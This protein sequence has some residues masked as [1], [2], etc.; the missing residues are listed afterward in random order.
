MD[1]KVILEIELSGWLVNFPLPLRHLLCNT[2]VCWVGLLE[3]CGI[4]RICWVWRLVIPAS[5]PAV[6]FAATWTLVIYICLILAI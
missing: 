2:A 6:H 4:M 1:V 3:L 5:T